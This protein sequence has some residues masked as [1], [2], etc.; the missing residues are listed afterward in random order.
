MIFSKKMENKFSLLILCIGIPGSGKSR[1]VHEYKKTHPLTYVVS[2]DEIRKEVTGVEQCINPS[3]ND[4]IHQLAR[5]RVKKILSDPHAVGGLGPEIIVDSTNVSA[6]EWIAYKE[7]HPALIIARIFDVSVETAMEHQRLRT[8][9]V[10]EHIVRLKY[11]SLQQNK[12]YLPYIF[13]AL[14]YE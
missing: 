2:T 3:Q 12:K 9:V 14:I 1:W 11:N 8:R 10:P 6:D 13:N 7:L 4:L 5:E